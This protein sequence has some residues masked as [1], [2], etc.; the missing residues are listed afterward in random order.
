[1]KSNTCEMFTGVLGQ[2]SRS[3][4]STEVLDCFARFLA[5][6]NENI[7]IE[8][9]FECPL[10]V[11]DPMSDL[12][13]MIGERGIRILAGNREEAG[14]DFCIFDSPEWKRI[15][16]FCGE[17][18]SRDMA[19]C[20][21][22]MW[23][24]FDLE[25]LRQ[26]IPLPGVF[27]P[28]PSTRETAP[29]SAPTDGRRQLIA[30]LTHLRGK[31]L[32][33]VLEEN[34]HRCLDAVP[35]RGNMDFAAIMLSRP[36]N[37]VRLVVRL[38]REDLPEYL[39]QIG[40]PEATPELYDLVSSLS[41]ACI[42]RYNLDISHQVLPRIGIECFPQKQKQANREH[43]KMFLNELTVQCLCLPAKRDA[44]LAWIGNTRIQL[45]E[46]DQAFFLFRRI[47]H[48]KIVYEKDRSSAAKAYPEFFKASE[49]ELL[50]KKLASN[51]E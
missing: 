31:P 1:M 51:P 4:V 2:V 26:K 40:Y 33:P 24:E 7:L 36:L 23:F 11:A 41:K 30:G 19:G 14:L 43:W 17:W 32:E 46:N 49:I 50:L 15:R 20:Q 12:S 37:A 38:S 5:R 8:G 18:I 3:L 35:Q 48:V 28:A 34:L 21:G 29:L 47:S 10:G 39:S 45:P 25:S 44:L 42:L 22:K 27:F 13:L 9:L 16:T 6:F